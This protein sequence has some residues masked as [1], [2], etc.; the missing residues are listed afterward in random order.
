MRLSRD[1]RTERRSILLQGKLM[2]GSSTHSPARGLLLAPVL[3]LLASCGAGNGEGLDANGQPIGSGPPAGSSQFQEIQDT[4]FTPICTACHLGA[5]APH[6]LRLDAANS[7][8]LLVN[9]ASDEVP[10]LKRVE[11]GDP[12]SSYIVQKI[13]GTAAVGG[14]MP[15]GG[16]QLP[17]DRIALIKAW[18]A[19]GAPAPTS[20]APAKL[21]VASTIPG[22]AEK[23]AAGLDKLVV[24]FQGDVDAALVASGTFELRDGTDAIVTL[25]KAEVPAG[26]PNV[27]EL[28]LAQPLP[29]GTY[30]LA[31]R[32][33]GPVAL[34]DNAGHV[35][36][37]DADGIPGGDFVMS[38]DVAAGGAQ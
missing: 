17:A 27:V 22:S 21:N 11:P 35:L 23:T 29:P 14:R 12:D 37:G 13:S 20:A 8:A 26:R 38:F 9:V 7:Y 32:G 25:A 1:R 6:G 36:D 10:A 33:E 31:V 3:V 2:L 5:N 16:A 24:I 19:A 30:Q 15:L 28:T 34:A 4:V 18:I